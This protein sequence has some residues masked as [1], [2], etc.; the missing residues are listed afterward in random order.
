MTENAQDRR[1]MPRVEMPLAF[2]VLV[3]ERSYPAELFDISAAGLQARLDPVTFD[4][5]REK[6]DGVRFSKGPPLAIKL[7]W[8][9]F[10]GTFGA[11]FKDRPMAAPIVEEIIASCSEAAGERHRE[12]LSTLR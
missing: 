2:D 1:D 10:D 7:H 3:D 12:Y 9:F 4:E 8:G 5:I 11:S 6:I